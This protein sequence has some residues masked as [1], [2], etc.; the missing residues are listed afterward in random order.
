M[1]IDGDT[2]EESL[3]DLRGRQSRI[4]ALLGIAAC[5]LSQLV[6]S[7]DPPISISQATYQEP[8]AFMRGGVD[9][10]SRELASLDNINLAFHE[11]AGRT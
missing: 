4:L 3:R 11:R 2:Y 1:K 8:W 7:Q 5:L 6:P 9:E 10:V